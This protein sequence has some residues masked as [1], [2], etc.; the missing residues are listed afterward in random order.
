MGNL[1]IALLNKNKIDDVFLDF[2]KAEPTH[3]EMEVFNRVQGTLAKSPG[4]LK[5]INEYKGAAEACRLAMSDGK[6]N[7]QLEEDAFLALVGCVRDIKLMTDF[8]E[9]L[10]E[11]LPLLLRA[12]AEPTEEKKHTLDDQ[13]ALAKQLAQ[14]LD[15]ILKF[16]RQRMQ[17]FVLPNDF[18]YYRRLLAKFAK[19]P[20]IE[21][22]EDEAQRLQ[23]FTADHIPMLNAAS[24]A[25]SGIKDAKADHYPLAFAVM[26]NSCLEMLKSQKFGDD[27]AVNSLCLNAMVGSLVLYD[28]VSQLG[29]FVGNSPIKAEEII[30]HLRKNKDANQPLLNAI[31][32]STRH[33]QDS[34]TP[35]SISGLFK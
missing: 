4:V 31:Q 11:V 32:Y 22:K 10:T 1:L 33:F 15:F 12:L 2:Q 35:R 18:S 29:A 24:R 13:Q 19:H 14:L 17:T 7:P 26:S 9:E 3:K 34:T 16:D 6:N 28:H 5:A 25:C 20:K 23:L 8:A 21:V 27:A 30:K